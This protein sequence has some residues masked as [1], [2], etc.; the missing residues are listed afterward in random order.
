MTQ[1]YLK[2][3]L[4]KDL[5]ARLPYHP[6][7]KIYNDSWEGCQCGEF[8][9]DLS[10]HHVEAFVCDRIE[11]ELYLRP[12]SSMTEEEKD[13]IRN[14]YFFEDWDSWNDL[15]HIHYH[16]I[17]IE[18]ISEFMDWLYAHHFDFPRKINGKLTTL[19]DLG[20][21]IGAPKDMYKI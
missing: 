15:L 7:I 21:A 9:N 20:L 13:F 16:E 4:L 19:A 3:L 5:C 1:E 18:E 12:M 6:Q 11:I 17:N 14:N 2:K 8:D 10:Y